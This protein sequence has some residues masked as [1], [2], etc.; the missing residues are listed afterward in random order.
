MIDVE[1]LIHEELVR[2]VPRIDFEPAPWQDVLRRAGELSRRRQRRI[3]FAVVVAVTLG[4]LATGP[5]GGAVIRAAGG[6]SVWLSGTPGTPAGGEVQ[7]MFEAAND[8]S[9]S[10]F[11]G[12][13][14]LHEL[15]HVTLDGRRFSLYG[16]ETRQVV[17]L[18]VAVRALEGAGPQAACVARADLRRSGDLVLPVKANL[19]VGHA[20]PVQRTASQPRTVPRYL[21][22]FGIAAAEVT[23]VTVQSDGGTSAAVVRNRAFLHVFRPGRR[24]NWARKIVA[25]AANGRRTV[26]PISVNVSGQP[27]LRTGLHPRGPAAAERTVRNGTIGWFVRRE[28]RGLSVDEAHVRI[29]RC[30]PSFVRVLE[31]DPKDFLRI[32]VSDRTIIDTPSTLPK[33]KV[34]PGEHRICVGIVTYGSAA[35]GCRTIEELFRDRPWDLSWG[36]SGAGQ[37]IW[38]VEGLVS[39]DVARIEVFLGT[40]VHWQAPLR[41]NATIFRVPRAKFPARIVAYDRD[42]RVIAVRTIRGG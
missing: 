18:R 33:P 31:P 23:R 1:P 38:M 5:L 37:Q 27:S 14:Q 9:L 42:G 36:F 26:V 8:R 32:L 34:Q 10:P 40:G 7:Q 39:D 30:C 13:P 29:P 11:P 20:G 21:L 4:A 3:A 28:Q 12:N 15:L 2:R 24:G 35:T 41:D 19:I 25:R 22:T 17:C 6:F 16:F